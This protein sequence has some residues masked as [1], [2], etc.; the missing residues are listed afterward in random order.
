VPVELLT[1]AQAAAFGR[2][3][4]APSQAELERFFFLDDAD[5]ERVALRRGAHNRLGFSVQLATVRY[6]GTFLADPL[7]M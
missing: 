4:G 3:T 7:V 5:L 6:L 2:F 1:D